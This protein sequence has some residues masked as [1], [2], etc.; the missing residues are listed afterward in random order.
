MR[1]VNCP[2]PTITG[3][4]GSTAITDLLTTVTSPG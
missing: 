3:V 1:S 2:T 4:R